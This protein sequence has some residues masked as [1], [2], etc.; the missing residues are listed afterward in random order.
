M[1]G[2]RQSE[3]ITW[4]F[5]PYS[6]HDSYFLTDYEQK[7]PTSGRGDNTDINSKWR[8]S[9]AGGARLKGP[10]NTVQAFWEE[11]EPDLGV[12]DWEGKQTPDCYT[13]PFTTK[14]AHS[15]TKTLDLRH[16]QGSHP[17]TNNRLTLRKK[18]KNLAGWRLLGYRLQRC[19]PSTYCG[20]S[21]TNGKSE[22]LLNEI[23]IRRVGK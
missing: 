22:N 9:T 12:G 18:M 17:H 13:H 5:Q 23:T 16:V 10:R 20:S 11:Q 2:S 7:K 4:L 21:Y 1:E 3:I 8:E 19:V 14:T 15:F 6:C